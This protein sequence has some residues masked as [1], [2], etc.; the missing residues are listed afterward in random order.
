M[1]RLRHRTAARTVSGPLPVGTN[2]RIVPA[3][4]VCTK[5]PEQDN[6]V[7]FLGDGIGLAPL[8][9]AELLV[10][11]AKEGT[12]KIDAYS[13]GGAVEELERQFAELLGKESAVFVATG[14]LANNLAL[15]LLAA[16]KSRVLVQAESHIYNDSYDCVQTL[17]HLNVV[18]LAAG[19]VG[20]TLDHVEEA[21]RRAAREP[22]PVEVGVISVECPIRRQYGQVFGFQQMERIAR[23]ARRHG[24]RMHLDGARLLIASAYTGIAPA[25]YAA[26]F[27]TVYASLYKGLNAASGAILAGPY[28]LIEQVGRDRKVFG[29]GLCQ[30]W[31][32]AAV[33]LHYLDGFAKRFQKAIAVARELFAILEKQPQFRGESFPG[34]TNIYKLHV[35]GADP[36]TY[37]AALANNGILVR[38]P[39]A[40]DCF[41]GVLLV[42][43]ETLNAPSPSELANLFINALPYT[44]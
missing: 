16:G 29:S 31:P 28:R 27:D 33:A 22:F 39:E 15:R 25:E 17:S 40:E 23:F 8:D 21:C 43:N 41:Q 12:A 7:H 38:E 19:Q 24:I 34:G 44:R 30:A 14:T 9:Y 35:S 6:Q 13:Y 4:T 42:V 26:L 11:L 3:E 36:A 2:G 32:Y 10:K 18:P 37:R 1:G 5:L 20:F